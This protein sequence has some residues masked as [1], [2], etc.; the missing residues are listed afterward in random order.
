[1]ER[2]FGLIPQQGSST[3]LFLRITKEEVYLQG[4]AI[5]EVPHNTLKPF[6]LLF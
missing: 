6:E 4:E 5:F 3:L 1:M 2:E